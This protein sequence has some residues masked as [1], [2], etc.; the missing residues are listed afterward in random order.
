MIP[1]SVNDARIRENFATFEDS[2]FVLSDDELQQLENLD[3]GP[4]GRRVRVA[5]PT[6]KYY[7]FDA[8]T[9]L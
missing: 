6:H 3:L 7:P 8:P 2:Q 5:D 1:K 9:K 4:S